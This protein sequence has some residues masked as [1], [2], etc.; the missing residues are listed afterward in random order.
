MRSPARTPT[1]PSR[2]AHSGRL[3]TPNGS[4]RR[5]RSSAGHR[6]HLPRQ[7]AE[8]G[9]VGDRF[10]DAAAAEADPQRPRLVQR[11]A[12]R[13][14][15]GGGASVPARM[16]AR[17]AGSAP[18]AAARVAAS[19]LRKPW[20]T[21]PVSGSVCRTA[22]CR[23]A[24]SL[25]GSSRSRQAQIT[26]ASSTGVGNSSA[27]RPP[28]RNFAAAGSP[29]AR[30][31]GQLVEGAHQ[32]PG[33]R[34]LEVPTP[35]LVAL[36][37]EQAGELVDAGRRVLATLRDGRLDLPDGEVAG[38]RLEGPLDRA[39]ARR[40]RRRRRPRRS[41]AG[42]RRGPA[43]GRSS[44][45][46]GR[47]GG[48]GG[49]GRRRA[50]GG[51]PA[52][53]RRRRR[54]GRSAEEELRLTR[55]P[56]LMDAI[57]G[58]QL[59]PLSGRTLSSGRQRMPYYRRVGEVP[60]KRHTQFR[61]PDGSLFAE[62]LMG[63]EGFSSDS[64]LLYHKHRPTAILS[65]TAVT[66]FATTRAREPAAQA[67]ALP[68]AQARRRA[69]RRGPRPAAPARQRRR[70]ACPTRSPRRRPRCTAT[71]SATS[72]STSRP[73]RCS[74]SPCS[75]RWTLHAGD[76]AIIPTSVIHRLVPTSTRCGSW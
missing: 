75:A 29:S 70:A 67:A 74:S 37:A 21:R 33:E 34:D 54:P 51:S 73:A 31:C 19:T 69:H 76:Y 62:E 48:R 9:Q 55:L 11:G 28:V 65:A 25:N 16:P 71:R 42:R 4:P 44:P 39:A 66:P 52:G 53:R 36:L 14:R 63:Q 5:A 35:R 57:Q 27:A 56:N 2:V 12:D 38:D 1:Q 26:A 43:A 45:P 68:D 8:V 10:V 13:G 24:V 49:P 41:R 60:P 50:A 58:G 15:R 22:W 64:S 3:C 59:R 46:T 72:A 61:Q 18:P 30:S 47:R 17:S 6:A 40:R 20:W 7:Q 32:S 23:P